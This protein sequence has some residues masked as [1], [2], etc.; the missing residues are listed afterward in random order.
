MMYHHD[1]VSFNEEAFAGMI[2]Q[3]IL[4]SSKSSSATGGDR[5]NNSNQN[6]D[7][8]GVIDLTDDVQFEATSE[9]YC[10]DISPDLVIL[11]IDDQIHSKWESV[12]KK[13][14]KF[15]IDM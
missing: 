15:L 3:H 9:S 12:A 11:M 6:H 10:D 1:S 4:G 5:G 8:N 2:L 14:G 13:Y 7:D